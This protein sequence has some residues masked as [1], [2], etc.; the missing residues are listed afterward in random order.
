MR[1]TPHA[2]LANQRPICGTIVLVFV[3][4]IL[5]FLLVLLVTV[6]LFD[7]GRLLQTFIVHTRLPV[8]Y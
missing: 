1:I 6:E 3:L 8:R 4:L 7:A 5:V 2:D